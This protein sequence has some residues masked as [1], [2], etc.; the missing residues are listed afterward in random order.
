VRFSVLF[1]FAF[2]FIS[3]A[4]QY[5]RG[6]GVYPGDPKEY[7]GPSLVVDADTYR[8][9]ALHRPAY[10]SSAY[11]YN[12]TSQLV[13]DGVKER[14]LP[15][16]LV[17]S[18]SN[19]GELPKTEREVFLDGNVVSSIDVSGDN[20]WVQFDIEGGG[21]IPEIDH[22]DLHLRK[23]NG[24][25]PTGGWTIV[26]SGSDD[27]A[28]WKEVGRAKGAAFP[29]MQDSGPSFAESIAFNAPAKFR[30]YR[31]AL[32]AAGVRTWGVGDLT[33]M[34]QGK[35]V[36]V[37]GPDIFSS[38][39]MSAGSGEEWVSV[40][41][42]AVCSFDR[43]ALAWI[44]RAA[45]GSIQVS[46]DN[47]QWQTV[48]PLAP[49][50][51][52]A[53][54]DL[55]LAQPAHGRFVRVLMTKPA[56]VGSRYILSEL[57]IY[58]RGG[59]VAVP[60]PAAA[61]AADGTLQLAAG[62]WHLQRVSLVSAN[63]EQIS[64]PGYADKDWMIATVPGTVLTSYLNDGAIANP[65]FGDNQYAVSDSFF[66]ADFWYRDEFIAPVARQAG[67]HYWLNFDGINW[68]AEIYMNGQRVGR[69][70]G[71]YMRG[72]FDVT[73]LLHPGGANSLAVRIIRT[74]NPGSTKDKAGRT[75]NGGA[76]GRDNPTYHAS[77]GWD[78]IST[79]RG[80]NTG[81]WS[82]VSLTTSAAVT[83]EN[84]LVTSTL[85][86]SDTSHADVTIQATVRN[87]EAHPVSGM[88]RASFGSVMVETQ[89]TILPPQERSSSRRHRSR[90]CA[91]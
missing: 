74:A 70:D 24:P 40:D 34:D 83:I 20:P 47:V 53:S 91:S 44:R 67:Q 8:N 88:L 80:R 32:S 23:M 17:A 49:N 66:C 50:G 48:Q 86:L 27:H 84:P 69:I 33:L 38:A 13:T 90:R 14:S 76:L 10:Q 43:V 58:G 46:N 26:V 56:D 79:I 68:K 15:Q 42:G 29:S 41:L 54:D 75:V 77:A 65:D 30:S 62:N 55:H 35:E 25:S 63:G 61:A 9:L 73:A 5:T 51:S 52:G 36:R 39:W 11:D 85:S 78:W 6:I 2:S 18:T 37:A 81:I 16:W 82:N 59:P 19:A 71:G 89:V 45:E 87:Q 64:A 3:S 1:I 21:T 60:K 22:I 4:Q 57:E 72:R 31:I 12:L 7:M 28:N